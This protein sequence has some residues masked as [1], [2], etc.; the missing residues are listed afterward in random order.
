VADSPWVVVERFA[1]QPE[2]SPCCL[3]TR[4]VRDASKRGTQRGSHARFALHVIV[5]KHLCWFEWL[6]FQAA[7]V[8]NVSY[9]G[10]QQTGLYRC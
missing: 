10:S 4:R 3:P 9:L 5:L 8:R 6:A 1:E 7:K 2:W